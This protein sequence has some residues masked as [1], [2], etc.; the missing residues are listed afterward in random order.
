MIMS[1]VLRK[2]PSERCLT[3]QDQ[4]RQAFLL[5][6]AHPPFREGIQIWRAWRKRQWLGA[7]VAKDRS[8]RGTKV[9]VPIMQDIALARK[10]AGFAGV[11]SSAYQSDDECLSGYHQL[12]S[13]WRSAKP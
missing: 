12:I 4:S 5:N 1:D 11:G 13:Q 7:T 2:G 10:S 3:E 9:R 6:R 8:E